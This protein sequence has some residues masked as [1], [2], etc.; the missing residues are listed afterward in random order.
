MRSLTAV[1]MLMLA[2]EI[3]ARIETCVLDEPPTPTDELRWERAMLVSYAND[4]I[5]GENADA[6][7]N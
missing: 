2:D 6:A 5:Y 4:I 3:T 1:Q 7:A